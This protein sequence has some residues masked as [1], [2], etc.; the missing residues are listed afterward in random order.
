MTSLS[1]GDLEIGPSDGYLRLHTYRQGLAAKAGHDLV[2]EAAEW[3]GR[4]HVPP[5]RGQS[6]HVEV[7]IDLRRLE[8]IAGTGGVRPLSDGDKV[9]IRKAMQ[10]PLRTDSHPLARF[11]SSRVVVDGERATVEGELSLAG[12]TH[13]LELEV[14]REPGGLVAGS[15]QVVQT[16][17]G[18]KPYTG[19]MGALKLR[20]AVDV[21]LEL[22]LPG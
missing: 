10:K 17:W 4:L 1:S 19:L 13:P 9:E 15:A 11:V 8:V 5:D 3:H 16:A 18:I 2:L 6:P 20:D 14:R 22:R 7:E 12:Q 21:E